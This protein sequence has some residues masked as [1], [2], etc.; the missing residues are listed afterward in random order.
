MVQLIYQNW[1]VE[2]PR[3]ILE[4]Q[5]AE[6]SETVD[7]L[8]NQILRHYQTDT[9]SHQDSIFSMHESRNRLTS[10]YRLIELNLEI[11]D[12]EAC[13]SLFNEL[14]QN[15]ELAEWQIAEHNNFKA[16]VAFRQAI[17]NNGKTYMQLNESELDA[18]RSIANN[19]TGRSSDMA[20]NILCFGYHECFI[21]SASPELRS[22]R[23]RVYDMNAT[24]ENLLIA[25]PSIV[26]QPNPVQDILQ[27]RL[28]GFDF[29]QKQITLQV[30]SIEGKL[31]LNE[32]VNQKLNHINIRNFENGTYLYRLFEGDKQ[33][34]EGK[35][36]V[37]H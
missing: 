23:N 6:H 21:G 37:L 3:G 5:L 31:L 30:F 20:Q 22:K 15:I 10:K 33:L 11:G 32:Q 12:W 7:L 16:Y 19:R 35:V 34:Q 17:S 13:S 36:I 26:L 25:H 27:V 2:S 1:D 4:D 29:E 8:A 28:R 9:L 14:D 18:L 24:D